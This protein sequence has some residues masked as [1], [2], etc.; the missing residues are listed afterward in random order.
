MSVETNMDTKEPGTVRECLRKAMLAKRRA[1]SP[2]FRKAASESAQSFLLDSLVWRNARVVFLYCATRNEP[3][4]RLLLSAALCE[5]KTLLL[6]KCVAGQAG[7]M[8]AV[9]CSALERLV[10]GAFGI[11]EPLEAAGE[12]LQDAPEPDLV[13]V[14]GVVFDRLGG[15]LGY[16]GGYYDRFL[17]KIGGAPTLVGFGYAFQV[18]NELPLEPWDMRVHALCLDTGFF[19]CPVPD[20]A[21]LQ[22]LGDSL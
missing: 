22:P 14:P 9:P 6:P 3:D 16:G 19:P 20:H 12:C 18:V 15:R 5:G 11:P 4:T 13:V 10:P 7:V 8:R 17:A 2:V 1:L 21:L